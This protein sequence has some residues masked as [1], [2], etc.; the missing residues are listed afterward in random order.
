M[1][2]VTVFTYSSE[3]SVY[4]KEQTV[5][6]EKTGIKQD[7]DGKEDFLE[8]Q[9]EYIEETEAY[10]DR[11]IIWRK[12]GLHINESSLIDTAK[13]AYDDGAADKKKREN[14]WKIK[15]K[16]Q[17]PKVINNGMKPE[18]IRKKIIVTVG[19][20]L[21]VIISGMSGYTVQAEE[22]ATGALEMTEE[23]RKEFLEN[24]PEI[25][26]VKLNE[27]GLALV[28]EA[29]GEKSKQ[30]DTIDPVGIGEE[31]VTDEDA[32]AAA[33]QSEDILPVSVDVS[34]NN[35]F[36][37]IGNQGQ[38]SSC[39]AWAN[40]YYMMTN[41][42]ANVRGWDAK[43]NSAYWISPKWVYNLITVSEQKK[44]SEKYIGAGTNTISA[45]RVL[46]EHGAPFYYELGDPDTSEDN[47]RNWEMK[48]DIW[49]RALKNKMEN[50]SWIDVFNQEKT[51][52]SLVNLK[53]TLLNGYVVTFSTCFN[54][55]ASQTGNPMATVVD[56]GNG[57]LG[58][59][60]EKVCCIVRKE[61][62]KEDDNLGYHTMTVVGYDDTIGIDVDGDGSVDTRGALKIANSHGMGYAN[63][64][65][66][67]LAYD[68]LRPVSEVRQLANLSRRTAINDDWFYYLKPKKQ[69]T[70]LLLAEV[71][72]Q[73][74][75]RQQIKLDFGIS[76][77][78]T[79][80]I[81]TSR[82]VNGISYDDIRRTYPFY[83][84]KEENFLYNFSG[85]ET[86]EEGTFVFDLTPLV[87][88][89]W[90]QNSQNVI[91]KK[92]NHF[93]IQLS[94]SVADNYATSLIKVKLIDRIG[95]TEKEVICN[96]KT[97][98]GNSVTEII[99][100][101]VLPMLVDSKKS[102]AVSYDYPVQKQLIDKNHVYIHDQ[103]N[104]LQDNLLNLS[105]DRKMLTIDT[106]DKGY[107]KD[108]YYTLIHDKVLT[109][110]GNVLENNSRFYFY[111]P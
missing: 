26:D 77:N 93:Y 11:Y 51:D 48:S 25:V 16:K 95:N 102:F 52:I 37:P 81:Q 9:Q 62:I 99:D 73:T 1:A 7:S 3:P 53:K 105:G 97:A 84:S 110:G 10:S 30:L 54:E 90:V 4:A 13:D 111:V 72:M 43:H 18:K 103:N 91:N 29:L 41:N 104:N 19:M 24:T 12:D 34:A 60:G 33:V 85:G 49:E 32:E 63:N 76:K 55:W 42:L 20:M 17:M 109:D 31:V 40:A 65:Y 39:T 71:T 106:T 101:Q 100:Y 59:I 67:W 69:Y 68:A 38:S 47:W 88:K 5:V 28:K 61:L 83:H 96:Q 80:T 21:C 57:G 79:E 45:L 56:I 8:L 50:Y 75:S 36:P 94:D 46:C 86:L 58:S 64:G 14:Q 78:I 87:K 89:F 92:S 2:F 107:A 6:Q 44:N 108:S 23:E 70:P 66:I 15:L 35:T 82:R 74:R 98:N 22:L 27:K